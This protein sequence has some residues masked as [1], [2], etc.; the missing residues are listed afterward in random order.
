MSNIYPYFIKFHI[1]FSIIFLLC[2]VFITIHYSISWAGN[3]GYGLRESRLRKLFLLL[4]YSD[5]II[6]IILYFFLQKPADIINTTEAMSFLSLRFWAIQHFTNI[7]F[8][9]ILCIVGNVLIKRT[10]DE[11]KKLKYSV[12]Y[13]GFST[14]VIIISVALFVLR[15]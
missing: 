3:K 15:K 13:F 12:L 14:L 10:V 7:V 11:R 5:L 1:G 8:V 6:G 4:L 9:T 2:I